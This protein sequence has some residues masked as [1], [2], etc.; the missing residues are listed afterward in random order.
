MSAVA[1]HYMLTLCLSI[2][3]PIFPMSIVL[4]YCM[5]YLIDVVTSN[6]GFFYSLVYRTMESQFQKVGGIFTL[7]MS[8]FYP[9]SVPQKTLVNRQSFLT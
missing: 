8:C 9:V 6:S 4:Q 7:K 3:F 1:S 5:E 2:V